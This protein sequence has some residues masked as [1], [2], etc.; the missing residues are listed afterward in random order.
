MFQL[1][2]TSYSNLETVSIVKNVGIACGIPRKEKVH[3]IDGGFIH[4]ARMCSKNYV[5]NG[6][7]P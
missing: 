2:T 3:V 5:L 4:N 1:P 6:Q 7:I